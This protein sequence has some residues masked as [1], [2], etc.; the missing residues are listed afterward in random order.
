MTLAGYRVK[1]QS[2][3]LFINECQGNQPFGRKEE[4]I[5]LKIMVKCGEKQDLCR[6]E[7]TCKD[8]VGTGL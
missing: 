1:D 3:S 5:R 6:Q 8:V 7:F 2:P 4:V